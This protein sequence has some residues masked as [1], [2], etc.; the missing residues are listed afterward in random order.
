M[1]EGFCE[2]GN[3]LSIFKTRRYFESGEAICECRKCGKVV[4]SSKDWKKRFKLNTDRSER[5]KR[6]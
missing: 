4:S 6:I 5:R 3:E 1:K 2:C